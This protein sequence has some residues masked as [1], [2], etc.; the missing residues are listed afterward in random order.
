MK[1]L[2]ALLLPLFVICCG[3][4]RTASGNVAELTACSWTASPEGGAAA[5]LVFADGNAALTVTNGGESEVIAGRYIADDRNLVI[6]DSGTKRNYSFSY[7]PRGDTLELSYAG[8]QIEMKA[9]E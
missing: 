3:C 9:A 4:A 5:K 1:K 8:E 2:V 6:F 7:V